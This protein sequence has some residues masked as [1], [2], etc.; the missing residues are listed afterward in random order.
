[1]ELYEYSNVTRKET[2]IRFLNVTAYAFV[3]VWFGFLGMKTGG[4][5]YL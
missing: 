2:Q 4:H 3:I 5:K 1:M